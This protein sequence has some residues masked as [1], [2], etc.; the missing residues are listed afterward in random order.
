[1]D[2]QDSLAER[3]DKYVGVLQLKHSFLFGGATYKIDDRDE[4][5]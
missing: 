4:L 2:D 5:G 3:I 1:M